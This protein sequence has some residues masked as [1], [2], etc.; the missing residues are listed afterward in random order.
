MI[1]GE[2]MGSNSYCFSDTLTK[3]YYQIKLRSSGVSS[4]PSRSAIAI[5]IDRSGSMHG[6]KLSD[7]KEAAKLAVNALGS[8]NFVSLYSFSTKT[9]NLVPFTKAGNKD[10]I[11]NSIDKIK[12]SGGTFMYSALDEIY[13][14]AKDFSSDG[15][16][17]TLIVLTDG[18]PSDVGDVK[19]YEQLAAAGSEFGMKIVCIGI[20]DY[21]ETILKAMADA[22]NGDFINAIDRN[23]ITSAFTKYAS[24]AATSGGTSAVLKLIPRESGA[25]EIYDQ[26]FS[27]ED[28][29]A[30]INLGTVGADPINATGSVSI[31]GGAEGNITGMQA[32]LSYRDN[33]GSP[34]ENTLSLSLIRTKNS[35]LVV[36]NVNK[37]LINEA[38]L[39]MQMGQVEYLIARGD[40]DSATRISRQAME[41][42][43]A[44]KKR[45]FIEATKRLDRVLDDSM[46]G[47]IDKK[48]AYNQTTRIKRQ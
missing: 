25:I 30:I 37:E 48:E 22:S 8:N 7:A 27:M 2:I 32:V 42:A 40:F 28:G 44:T 46:K 35:E 9:D 12:A 26:T 31:K 29:I 10:K 21:D 33:D 11:L 4:A 5:L 45:E 43:N 38:R 3:I 16:S 34:R 47:N 15:G 13:H 20:G 36:S 23:S 18:Q 1:E 24:E 14:D 39:K 41:S 19:R 6:E 17:V